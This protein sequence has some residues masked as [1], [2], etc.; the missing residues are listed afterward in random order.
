MASVGSGSCS[1]SCTDIFKNAWQ[2]SPDT[3]CDW[4]HSSN[5]ISEL[6]SV[7]K[8]KRYSLH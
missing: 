3:H 4:I 6:L 1:D 8:Q 5:D 7:T 2:M